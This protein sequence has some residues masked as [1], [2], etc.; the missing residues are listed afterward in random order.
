MAEIIRKTEATFFGPWLLDSAAL[1]ALDEIIDEQWLRLEAHKREQIEEAMR[2]ARER[3]PD[4]RTVDDKDIRRRAENDDRYQGDGRMI[5]L[6]LSSGNKVRVNSFREA[7]DDVNCQDHEVTKLEVRLY[8]GGIRGDLVVPVLTPNK[9][10]GLSL[11]TLPEASE[12]ADELFVRLRKWAEQYKPDLFRQMCGMGPLGAWATFGIFLMLL[13]MIGFSTGTIYETS[14]WKDEV[15]ELLAN[16][17]NPD[18][19]GRALELLLQKVASRPEEGA[20]LNLPTWFVIGAAILAV[21]ATLFTIK[22]RTAFEIGRGAASVYRQK[23]YD[24]FLRK[25]VPAFLI[26]GV[27]ASIL[28]SVFFEFMR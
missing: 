26:M 14:T 9:G 12:R 25:I 20:K 18:N 1:A 23:Q 10:P 24:R 28:G 16:G 15:R 27:S 21:F 6:T 19:Q 17:V 7:A 5:V 22:A 3:S 2:Q 13:A 11:V 8:C 4:T